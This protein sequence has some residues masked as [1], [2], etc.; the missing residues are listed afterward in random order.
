MFGKRS[1]VE[2]AIDALKDNG[3][4]NRKIFDFNNTRVSYHDL[5]CFLKELNEY[6]QEELNSK[7]YRIIFK[8]K[9]KH[10]IRACFQARR[11]NFVWFYCSSYEKAIF[12][13][14]FYSQFWFMYTEWEKSLEEMKKVIHKYSSQR[15]AYLERWQKQKEE[16]KAMRQLGFRTMKL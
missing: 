7:N 2:D 9:P 3:I 10:R 5:Q 4:Q 15:I 8:R 14:P 13:K 16:E 11:F 6:C 1:I 12:R